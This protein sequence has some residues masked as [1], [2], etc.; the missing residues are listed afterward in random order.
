[1]TERKLKEIEVIANNEKYAVINPA[2][3][4]LINSSTYAFN[5]AY[6]YQLLSDA[7][8]QYICNRIDDEGLQK[9]FDIWE[10]LVQM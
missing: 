9:A 8:T 5:G 3:S 4:Y 10:K 1:M 2:L 7:R 6:L